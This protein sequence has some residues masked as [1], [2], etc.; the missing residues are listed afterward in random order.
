MYSVPTF[1]C[2]YNY[3]ADAGNWLVFCFFAT[4][5]TSVAITFISLPYF[6]GGH[7]LGSAEDT[8]RVAWDGPAIVGQ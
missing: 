3:H 4:S 5:G 8:L 2:I 1:Q 6:F 7:Y